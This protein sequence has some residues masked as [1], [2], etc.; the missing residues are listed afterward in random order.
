MHFFQPLLF[1]VSFRFKTNNF[2]EDQ[3]STIG[4][5]FV[6]KEVTVDD[7]KVKLQIWDTSGQERFRAVTQSYYRYY[8][9]NSF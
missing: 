6:L 8:M 1:L 3:K 9:I 4:I 7:Q 2:I 5:D